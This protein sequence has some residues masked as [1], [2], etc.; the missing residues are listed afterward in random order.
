MEQWGVV[1]TAY[2][3]AHYHRRLQV[4]GPNQTSLS[5]ARLH[6]EEELSRSPTTCRFHWKR[7]L[8]IA[9]DRSFGIEQFPM[10]CRK[11]D[12]SEIRLEYPCAKT[13]SR[14]GSIPFRLQLARE[15]RSFPQYPRLGGNRTSASSPPPLVLLPS[16]IGSPHGVKDSPD[17][18][19]RVMI[20]GRGRRPS[21]PEPWPQ[22][23]KKPEVF[24]PFST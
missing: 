5:W 14:K 19:A 24:Y 18:M 12:M 3:R 4:E 6:Q 15:V 17:N 20:P 1:E 10:F 2:S 16:M 7:H 8:D 9:M 21:I 11:V 13:S 23:G 22:R